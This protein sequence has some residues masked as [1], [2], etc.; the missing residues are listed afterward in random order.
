M[1][2]VIYCRVATADQ[3]ALDTQEE[4]LKRY[5]I[6]RGYTIVEIV[7]EMLPGRFLD[8]PGIQ[9]LQSL[10]MNRSMDAVIT[11]D[12]SRIS[13]SVIDAVSFAKEMRDCGVDCRIA[14]KDEVLANLPSLSDILESERMAE[15]VGQRLARQPRGGKKHG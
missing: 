5:A 15:L 8:R 6:A 3:L 1:K 10:A 13:R 12:Y 9:R 14:N 7:K 4:R 11:T 2:V